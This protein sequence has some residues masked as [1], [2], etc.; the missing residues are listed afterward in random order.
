MHTGLCTI[1]VLRDESNLFY[2]HLFKA[3]FYCSLLFFPFSSFFMTGECMD[4][5]NH[6]YELKV[7]FDLLS[8]FSVQAYIPYGQLV[9]K[10]NVNTETVRGSLFLAMEYEIF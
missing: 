9:W 5:S 3:F 2:I 6:N 10:Q 7:L 1:L 8:S 4:L